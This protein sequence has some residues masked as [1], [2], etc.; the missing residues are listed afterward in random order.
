[1]KERIH[2]RPAFTL[3]ELLVTLGILALLA[4]LAIPMLSNV[5]ERSRSATQAYSLTDTAR[6]LENFYAINHKYP[7]GWDSLTVDGGGIYTSLS[8]NLESPHTFL[9]TTTI[10]PEQIT[11]LSNAG[12]G[13][14]FLHNAASKDYSNS[15]VDRRH[16]GTGAGHDGT[17][18][19]NTLVMID[20]TTGS[21]GLNLLVNGFGLNPNRSATDT[22]YPRIS[23]NNYIVFGL[24]PKS[25]AV[26]G[27]VQTV[28][29][30]D[31]PQ[32]SSSYSRALVVFE[33]PLT[34]TARAKMVGVLGPDGRGLNESI[35]DY[36]N[37]NGP[38]PH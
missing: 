27:V 34:G 4:L 38:Q 12:I 5:Y 22:T 17:T 6:M 14:V 1:M 20:K 8:P 21:D 19:V 36:N 31:H 10:T 30:L 26:Q 3:M 18:N 23:A 15:G 32:S 33:V 24:G 11:S 7:D 13:H 9:T 16:M 25:T 2:P 35:A 37:V 28:P 29:L